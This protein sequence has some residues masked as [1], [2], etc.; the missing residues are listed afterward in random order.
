MTWI[1]PIIFY[2]FKEKT[3]KVNRLL[4]MVTLLLNHKRITAVEFAQRFDVST[5]TIYR[6]V[7]DLSSAGIPVYMSKGKG[8]G[9]SLL[10]N[11]TLNKAL[12]TREESDSLLM[13]V[14]TLQ[15]TRYPDVD[16]FLEKLESLFR[17]S[18]TNRWIEIDFSPWGTK[19]GEEDLF[20]LLRH[21]ILNRNVIQFDYINFK[22]DRSTRRVYP[23]QMIYKGNAWYMR[24]FCLAR[25][26]YRTFR[27][28]RI[29]SPMVLPDSFNPMDLPEEMPEKNPEKPRE[30]M[31]VRLLFSAEAANRIYDDFHED[32]VRREPDGRFSLTASLVDDDWIYSLI[33]SYGNQVEVLE[34]EYLRS[35]VKERLMETLSL[36]T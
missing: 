7:E 34:P 17:S 6:D 24:G 16:R 19:A 15:A 12:I 14:K 29:K 31:H 22:G 32:M 10:E 5:R 27:L 2:T 23:L 30:Y 1:C 20:N 11:F 8:G 21:S 13:A 18:G 26:D 33:L 35:R 28:S 9:I 36:Y 4:E 25:Q 3:M